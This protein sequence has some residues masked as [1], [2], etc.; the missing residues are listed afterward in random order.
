[1]GGTGSPAAVLA[2]GEGVPQP[3]PV[4][5]MG[6]TGILAA[7]GE[8]DTAGVTGTITRFGS[9]CVNG[10]RIGYGERTPATRDGAPV[11]AADLQ[12]GQLVRVT[13]RLR[14]GAL[15]A[16]RVD[17]LS[18]VVG[19]VTA[20]DEATRRFE[21]IGQPVRLLDDTWIALSGTAVPPLGTRVRVSGLWSPLGEVDASRLEAARA[22][23]PDEV[24][25]RVGQRDGR[26]AALGAVKVEFP[27]DWQGV[28]PL[29]AQ[30]LAV[31]G[32][33]DGEV[34]QVADAQLRPRLRF[35]AAARGMSLEGFLHRCEGDPGF[36]LDGVRL[37]FGGAE[38]PVT[39]SGRR[40]VVEG[41]SLAD[42]TIEVL[43][44]APS[45]FEEGN[46]GDA[47]TAACDARA[48]G[49]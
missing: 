18:A 8:G 22:E 35:A 27:P 2:D 32:R 20:R 47:A 36:G 24:L 34:L 23:E 15:E 14:G 49:G 5:G 7:L 45:P 19:T 46:A 43:R 3:A 39:W 13:A 33:W 29:V 31:R 1:M 38:P 4:G 48:E 12:A 10:L 42:G 26:Y 17:L 11:S 41:T 21:V 44:V 6:G 16:A 25:A 40:V 9:I 37:R 28:A 30:E